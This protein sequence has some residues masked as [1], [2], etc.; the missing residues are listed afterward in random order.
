MNNPYL[1][2]EPYNPYGQYEKD[3]YSVWAIRSIY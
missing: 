2:C 1:Q 3:L